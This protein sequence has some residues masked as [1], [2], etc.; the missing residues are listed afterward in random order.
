MSLHIHINGP[1][2]VRAMLSQGLGIQDTCSRAH[3][4]S[5]TLQKLIDGHMVRMDS[6]GRVNS[7]ARCTGLVGASAWSEGLSGCGGG[8]APKIF[9]VVVV[10]SKFHL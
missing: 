2:I 3:L 6:V 8:L 5:K 9:E 10:I 4:S 1:A 7:R